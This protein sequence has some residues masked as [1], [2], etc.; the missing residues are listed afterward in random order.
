MKR[1]PIDE[2]PA[3]AEIDELA[4]RTLVEANELCHEYGWW[5]NSEGKTIIPACYDCNGE[6]TFSPSRYIGAAWDL[7]EDRK[8]C[9]FTDEYAISINYI[10]SESIDIH[11]AEWQVEFAG[12]TSDEFRGAMGEAGEL[13]LA[14]TRAYLKA[15]GIKFVE[16]PDEERSG[17]QNLT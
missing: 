5:K 2:C 9:D 6:P 12:S 4:M 3:G 13:P 10:F 17:C 11:T 7:I 16:A 8:R 1:I 14:I 15:R